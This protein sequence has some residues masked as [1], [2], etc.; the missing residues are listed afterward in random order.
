MTL[1]RTSTAVACLAVGLIVMAMAG[2]GFGPV[3]STPRVSCT[4]IPAGRCQALILEAERMSGQ[5]GGPAIVSIVIR[6]VNPPCTEQACQGETIVVFADGTSSSATWGWQGAGPPPA[7]P[8][9]PPP[10]PP[11][12]GI[13]HP[14][15]IAL[16]ADKCAEFA[17]AGR[18]PDASPDPTI[19]AIEVACTKLPCT[20]ELGMGTTTVIH[21]DGRREVSQWSYSGGGSLP[22]P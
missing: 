15:C 19:V 8:T 2:C 20:A 9:G 1:S 22:S 18:F 3:T 6:A 14:T 16:P 12:D 13:V 10:P 5:A 21:E 17:D 11:P 4:G 7:E